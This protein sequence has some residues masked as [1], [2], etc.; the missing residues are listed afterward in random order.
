MELLRKAEVLAKAKFS[1][2][3]RRRLTAAGRF[4]E[5]RFPYGPK[6]SLWIADEVEAALERLWSEPTAQASDAAEIMARAN[7]ARAAEAL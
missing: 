1:D 2:A 3:T 5:P 7:A 4:P 6:S